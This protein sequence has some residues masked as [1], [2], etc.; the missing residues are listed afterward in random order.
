MEAMWQTGPALDRAKTTPATLRV[1]MR[2]GLGAPGPLDRSIRAG[3]E[4]CRDC[5]LV[6]LRA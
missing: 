6:G 2:A 5:C 3:F 1:A 4:S